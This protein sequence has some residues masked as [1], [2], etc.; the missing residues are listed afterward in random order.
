MDLAI[1]PLPPPWRE[2]EVG[3]RKCYLNEVTEEVSEV[4]PLQ[5]ILD[6]K[7]S[8]NTQLV[9]NANEEQA[10]EMDNG[11]TEVNTLTLPDGPHVEFRCSW[12]EVGLFGDKNS[13]GLTLRYYSSHYTVIKFDGVDGAWTMSALEG[14]YGPINRLDL[15]IG[16]RLKL[17]GR[18][19]TIC[20]ANSTVCKEIDTEGKKLF[21]KQTWLQERIEAQGSKPVV[22]KPFLPVVRNIA[23]Q[24]GL[25][26]KTTTEGGYMN[27]RKLY[28]DNMLLSEQI[29]KLGL[30]SVL[31]DYDNKNPGVKVSFF[32]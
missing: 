10:C 1:L 23:R 27:L 11:H 30:T 15:Y 7:A 9:D 2:V 4:H 17:F 3:G 31:R 13:F 19:M 29:Q 21:K 5:A 20:S 8:G 18:H 22:S 12:T 28:N 6:M 26:H 14:S 24:S 16:G 32:E 25:P